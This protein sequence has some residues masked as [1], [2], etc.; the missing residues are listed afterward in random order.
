MTTQI[1]TKYDRPSYK[2]EQNKAGTLVNKAGYVS[3][4]IR[5]ENIID[6]GRRLIK[7]REEQYD[8][9]DKNLNLDQPC[10]PLRSKSVDFADLT[11]LQQR[12]K[13]VIEELKE[14]DKKNKADKVKADFE[15]AVEKRAL[16]KIDSLKTEKTE[17][18]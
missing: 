7:Y 11:I 3:A 6:A 10:D 17:N 18:K 12:I 15:A 8:F 5:I 1:Y 9:N 2:K 13:P 4:K 16:E 14:L